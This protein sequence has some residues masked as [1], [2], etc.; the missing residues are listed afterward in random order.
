MRLSTRL[1][2]LEAKAPR[3]DV[4]ILRVL[5][6]DEVPSEADRCPRCGG[7]HVVFIRETIVRTREDVE[8]LQRANESL[9]TP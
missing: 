4:L 8:R 5:V 1:R 6:D 3:C 2:K 9:G 7:C